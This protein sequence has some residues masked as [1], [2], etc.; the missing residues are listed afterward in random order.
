MTRARKDVYGVSVPMIEGIGRFINRHGLQTALF[1]AHIDIY[2]RTLRAARGR[3]GAALELSRTMVAAITA[4]VD[5]AQLPAK[6]KLYY[7]V[8]RVLPFS[9]FL[10]P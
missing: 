9:S 10:L 5:P 3:F 2:V 7:F 8:L 1:R 4:G 6:Q